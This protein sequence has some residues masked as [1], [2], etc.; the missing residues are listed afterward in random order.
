M[1]LR[2]NRSRLVVKVLLVSSPSSTVTVSWFHC[3]PWPMLPACIGLR[4]IVQAS[5]SDPQLFPRHRHFSDWATQISHNSGRCKSQTASVDR[6]LWCSTCHI[7]RF[8]LIPVPFVV[9]IP[10]AL[11]SIRTL[12]EIFIGTFSIHDDDGANVCNVTHSLDNRAGRKVESILFPLVP[13][14]P[15]SRIPTSICQSLAYPVQ[16]LAKKFRYLIGH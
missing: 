6:E 16:C 1:L 10:V 13:S 15:V 12:F 8:L 5:I 4:M 3:S 11:S 7:S 2:I 9:Q 14:H